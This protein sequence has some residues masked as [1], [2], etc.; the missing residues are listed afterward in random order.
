MPKV[1]NLYETNEN[2]PFQVIETGPGFKL[3]NEDYNT[4]LQIFESSW[5]NTGIYTLK[6]ENDSGVDEATVEIT[7]LGMLETELIYIER[8]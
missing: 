5:K 6:A 4:R 7:V 8:V 2:N 1:T 3:E